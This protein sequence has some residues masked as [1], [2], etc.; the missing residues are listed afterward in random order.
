MSVVKIKVGGREVDATVVEFKTSFIKDYPL[1]SRVYFNREQL[2]LLGFDEGDL[3]TIF[4]MKNNR[5]L[6]TYNFIVKV[7]D[8]GLRYIEIPTILTKSLNLGTQHKKAL[9]FRAGDAGIVFVLLGGE[10]A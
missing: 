9:A 8:G 1:F 7:E 10:G 3:V 2:K 5:T 6:L 4:F